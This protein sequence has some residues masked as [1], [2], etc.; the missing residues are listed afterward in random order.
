MLNNKNKNL[1]CLQKYSIVCACV[2]YMFVYTHVHVHVHMNRTEHGIYC[3]FGIDPRLGIGVDF[4]LHE[5]R[6]EYFLV[7]WVCTDI[8][9]PFIHL[10]HFC[11]QSHKNSSLPLK[12]LD[13][14]RSI[15]LTSHCLP[16]QPSNSINPLPLR[17]ESSD[18]D[19]TPRFTTNRR[20][21]LSIP[22]RL[23]L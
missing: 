12:L 15:A 18:L 4:D 21:N 11:F 9:Q 8:T 13:S 22:P 20:D 1:C 23:L 7:F 16:P 17:L 3:V 10:L 2:M 14:N 19:T 5:F 6:Q